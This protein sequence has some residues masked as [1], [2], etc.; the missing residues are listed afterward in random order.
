MDYYAILGIN[1]DANLH[2]VQKAYVDRLALAA[3]ASPH[4]CR[5]PF[6]PARAGAFVAPLQRA[7]PAAPVQPASQSQL[8]RDGRCAC[9][10]IACGWTGVGP[11]E[12]L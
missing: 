4:C 2:E 3:I 5:R 1:R 7:R 6:P 8:L 9:A 12:C 11:E 10:C